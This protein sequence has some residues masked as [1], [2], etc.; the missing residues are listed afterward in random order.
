MLWASRGPF[1]LSSIARGP[2]SRALHSST[3]VGT[4]ARLLHPAD[5]AIQRVT[6]LWKVE[7]E[8]IFPS[9]SDAASWK[10][11]E[12][13]YLELSSTAQKKVPAKLEEAEEILALQGKGER[14]RAA[15]K[16]QR[17]GTKRKRAVA[18]LD[19][20]DKQ[21]KRGN[22][23]TAEIPKSELTREFPCLTCDTAQVQAHP[24]LVG[25][26]GVFA[27]ENLR[28][29]DIAFSEV[30]PLVSKVPAELKGS[31]HY[32]AINHG[33]GSVT[34]PTQ[35]NK[36]K[37]VKGKEAF[38]VLRME[39][40]AHDSMAYY[41]NSAGSSSNVL[42]PTGQGANVMLAVTV[43][44]GFAGV[45]CERGTWWLGRPARVTARCLRHIAAGEE[46][47][48]AYDFEPPS[49][50]TAKAE[51]IPRNRGHY[52]RGSDGRG[53][54]GREERISSDLE[55]LGTVDAGGQEAMVHAEASVDL[56]I[57]R[58][59][60]G[61]QRRSRRSRDVHSTNLKVSDPLRCS[62]CFHCR[63]K[64]GKCLRP[65]IGK[66]RDTCSKCHRSYGR[67]YF[68]MHVCVGHPAGLTVIPGRTERQQVT[69]LHRSMPNFR[70]FPTRCFADERASERCSPARTEVPQRPEHGRPRGV[71]VQND[72][73]GRHQEDGEPLQA[74]RAACSDGT[75]RQRHA[76]ETA[77]DFVQR[78][79]RGFEGSSERSYEEEIVDVEKGCMGHEAR[80]RRDAGVCQ[81]S[82][83][84]RIRA[85]AHQCH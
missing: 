34:K 2:C 36:R 13:K 10:W 42:D 31:D 49:P 81:I 69:S 46:L 51:A 80:Q 64:T 33:A 45:P 55:H 59:S 53:R 6:D 14:E 56:P 24:L 25:Q 78:M 41:L 50:G 30:L 29:E 77:P 43:G 32:I 16:L 39:S 27:T 63:L 82:S 4:E 68:P 9:K 47:L 61:C 62:N 37:P 7:A 75:G 35:K 65:G 72:C 70:H 5:R 23:E 44:H 11:I 12:D 17:T 57:E 21:A 15:P 20:K 3:S 1:L 48:W 8:A 73:Q 54:N 71:H 74:L 26:Q 83:C 52:I 28:R 66:H 79:P 84:S 85:P 76:S 60:T 40:A 18:R 22:P 58:T 38:L 67:A 19:P